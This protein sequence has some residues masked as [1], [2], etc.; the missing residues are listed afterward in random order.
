L[1]VSTA[2]GRKRTLFIPAAAA[3]DADEGGPA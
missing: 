1:C 2:T 3:D